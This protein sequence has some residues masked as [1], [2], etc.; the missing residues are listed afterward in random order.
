M[1]LQAIY[2][3][4]SF[5]TFSQIN[6]FFLILYFKIG[7]NGRIPSTNNSTEDN[8]KVLIGIQR[9]YNP[10]NDLKTP[11]KDCYKKFFVGEISPLGLRNTFPW[12]KKSKDLRYICQ[13]VGGETYYGTMF[14]EGTGIPVFSAYTVTPDNIQFQ[15]RNP[16]KWTQTEGNLLSSILKGG[17][18]SKLFSSFFFLGCTV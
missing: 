7:N 15:D 14:D 16:S 10:N 17:K 2:L 11:F 18:S 3:N 1:K 8:S 4:N 6:D 5:K 13:Q 9:S 12:S